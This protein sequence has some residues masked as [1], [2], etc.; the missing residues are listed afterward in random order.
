MLALLHGFTPFG[1]Y[2]PNPSELLMGSVGRAVRRQRGGGGE[3]RIEVVTEVLP[4]SGE[5]V[6]EQVPKLIAQYRPDVWMGVGLAAGR[7]SLSLEAVALNLAGWVEPDNDGKTLERGPVRA[8][9][10]AAYLTTLP[11]EQI[12]DGWRLAGIPGYLSQTAGS[13]CCNQS[14][15]VA[16]HAVEELGLRCAVGFLHVPLL[17]EQVTEPARQPSM[18]M[19]LQGAG[20]AIAVNASRMSTKDSGPYLRRTE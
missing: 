9:G 16:A 20:L 19:H 12:L 6:A 8:D 2:D 14:F 5:S 17:P 15:Y 13:F 10:P 18:A 11:V 7:P 1:E 3:D 4:V